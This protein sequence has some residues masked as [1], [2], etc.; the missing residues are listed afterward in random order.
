MLMFALFPNSRIDMLSSNI[1]KQN[2]GSYSLHYII[3][4]GYLNDGSKVWS[5]V[6]RPSRCGAGELFIV[7]N[8]DFGILRQLLCQDCL[9]HGVVADASVRG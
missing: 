7:L 2:Y 3:L 1:E 6:L 8:I 9:R 4:C 5:F